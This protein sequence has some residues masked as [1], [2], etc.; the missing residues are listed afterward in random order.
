[1]SLKS[2]SMGAAFVAFGLRPRL[3]PA[4]LALSG[5]VVLLGLSS[6]TTLTLSF[7]LTLTFSSTCATFLTAGLELSL[8]VALEAVL[9]LV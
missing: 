7:A 4:A 2:S 8:P 5:A 1:M 3:A 9:L 6:G